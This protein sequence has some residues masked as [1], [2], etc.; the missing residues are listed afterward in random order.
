[1]KVS[2][3]I[4]ASVLCFCFVLPVHAQDV[5]QTL[6]LD[7]NRDF[8]YGGFGGD[9]QGRFSLKVSSPDDIVRVEY[10]LDGELVYQG[11]EPPFRWQFNTASF[12]E[13]KHVFSAVGY[14]ADGSQ[15][16]AEEFSRTFLSSENAWSQTGDLIVPIL[17]IVGIATLGGVLG[18]V[19]L[20]RNK[21]HTPGVYGMAGGAVCPRCTFPYSRNMMSPNLLVGKL[22][23]CPHCGKWA[24]VPRAAPADL[25]AAEGRF[26]AGSQTAI[27]APTEEDKLQQMIEESRYDQ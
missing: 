4:I 21:T 11:N 22:S 16:Q 23:R 13:G 1:M 2:L 18:P 15:L 7:F 14:R 19:L 12:S 6:V 17:V 8:G 20:G 9:I 5:D 25:Q 27:D 26:A 3:L 10:F 24:I